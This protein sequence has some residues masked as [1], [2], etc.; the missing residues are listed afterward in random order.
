M[1]QFFEHSNKHTN[2]G[3][4][5]TLKLSYVGAA[6]TIPDVVGSFS[7][8]QVLDLSHNYFF[9]SVPQSIANL[10]ELK[11]LDLSECLLSSALP[12]F[13]YSKYDT[14]KITGNDFSC[15]LPA[16]SSDSCS[17]TCDKGPDISTLCELGWASLQSDSDIQTAQTQL[18]QAIGAAEGTIAA[19]VCGTELQVNRTCTINVDLSDPSLSSLFSNLSQV[20]EKKN[21]KLIA[22]NLDKKQQCE[23][24]GPC[25]LRITN[26]T[27]VAI[28]HACDN[29]KDVSAFLTWLGRPSQCIESDFGSSCVYTC[30]NC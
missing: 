2:T 21:A 27:V 19:K 5:T 23:N 15:P 17:A 9:G 4:I 30:N 1:F 11:T 28:P 8:L 16:G 20:A 7:K 24:F 10:P 18:D 26:T 3:H 25:E 12:S 14:C 29:D 22:M 13:D 6:S